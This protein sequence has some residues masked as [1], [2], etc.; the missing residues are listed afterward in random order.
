MTMRLVFMLA[1]YFILG[2]ALALTIYT[3]WYYFMNGEIPLLGSEAESAL[4]SHPDTFPWLMNLL[5]V[6]RLL[7]GGV[8]L[9]CLQ[10]L[11]YLFSQSVFFSSESVRCFSW[12]V[13]V[14]AGLYCYTIIVAVNSKIYLQQRALDVALPI[15]IDFSHVFTIIISFALIHVLRHANKIEVENKEFI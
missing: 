5:S 15:L 3:L 6:P 1:R 13:W 9:F 8:I 10:K 4:T 7:G 14:N 12:I 2:L 11:F